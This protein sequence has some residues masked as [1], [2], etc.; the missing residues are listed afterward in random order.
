M[1]QMTRIASFLTRAFLTRAVLTRAVIALPL[2]GGASGAALAAT[3]IMRTFVSGTGSDTAACT[4]SA[5]CKTFQAALA[6]TIAGGEIFVL[7]SSNFGQVT[8]TKSVTITS[9][10][11]VAG[12]LA[13]S[14][15]GINIAAGAN[16]VVNLRGLDIDGGN[17]GNIGI[18]FTSGL[19]LNIQ[20]TTV[21]GFANTGINFA[22]TGASALYIGD[23]ALTNNRNNG[24]LVSYGGSARVN[25][26]L[27]RV[28][29]SGNGVGV[30][31]NGANVNVTMTDTV[32]GNNSYGVGA[33]AASVMVR[34]SVVSNNA[35]GIA[36]DQGA[37]VRV[38]QSTVTANGTGWQAANGGQVQ[39][40]GNNNVAGNTSD[41]TV[42]STVALQ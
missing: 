6:A 1:A 25:G 41:G 11:A 26:A 23:T 22:P 10:G 29:A 2:L 17:T 8:I 34:N 15:V 27:N 4:V 40:F 35:V 37:I 28:T 39:S 30:F 38:G 7:N 36:A 14:G 24:V 13:A 5:P 33:T 16:D 21:R 31:A 42:T 32:T 9:E 18:Q 19:A 3:P 12:I 20:R